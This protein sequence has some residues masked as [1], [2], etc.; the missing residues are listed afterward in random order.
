MDG[1]AAIVRLTCG[2]AREEALDERSR[3]SVIAI[4]VRLFGSDGITGEPSS[5]LTIEDG[6]FGSVAALVECSSSLGA[7]VPSSSWIAFETVSSSI[8][9]MILVAKGSI[10]SGGKYTVEVQESLYLRY[11]RRM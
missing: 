4:A 8:L 2:G 10:G 3:L 1:L 11:R 9:G 5:S 6:F 7:V